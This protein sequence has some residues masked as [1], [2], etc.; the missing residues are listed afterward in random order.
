MKLSLTLHDKTYS[1]ESNEAFDG[2]NV[3]ELT[4]QFK[5]LLVNAGFHPS[6]VDNMFNTEY[7]WFTEEERRD[8]MQGH[9]KEE[10]IMEKLLRDRK[11][12]EFQDNLYK[13]DEDFKL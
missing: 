9:L 13:P 11:V 6:N 10:D 8:N 4:E 12:Q 7:Q 2:T 3:N 5:G 1:V